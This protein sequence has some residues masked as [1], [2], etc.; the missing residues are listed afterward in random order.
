MRDTALKPKESERSISHAHTLVRCEYICED[1]ERNGWKSGL[2]P[3]KHTELNMSERNVSVRGQCENKIQLLWYVTRFADG[4]LAYTCSVQYSI[5]LSN[6][7]S[8]FLSGCCFYCCRRHRCDCCYFSTFNGPRKKTAL[9][10]FIC[11]F[12]FTFWSIQILG[13][14]LLELPFHCHLRINRNSFILNK[15]ARF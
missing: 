13:L 11:C 12:S 1:R 10:L 2:G 14:I 5:M 7:F 3:S 6:N 4:N 9:S 15:S 8:F